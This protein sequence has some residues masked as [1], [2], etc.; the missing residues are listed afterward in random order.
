MCPCPSLNW[1]QL[2]QI[3]ASLK[4]HSNR[5]LKLYSSVIPNPPSIHLIKGIKFHNKQNT[6]HSVLSLSYLFPQWNHQLSTPV[7][8]DL[9]PMRGYWPYSWA[10]SPCSHLSI[11]T[12]D[13]RSSRSLT[14]NRFVTSIPTC[15]LFCCWFWSWL[16][17]CWLIWKRVLPGL[18]LTGYIGWGVL[19]LGF[20]SFSWF[21][22]WF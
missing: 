17:L 10:S 6:P 14:R 11:S 2:Y 21:L 18:M 7:P 8:E 1:Q 20:L 3:E 12:G 19:L 13:P 9:Y 5:K 4:A 22:H 15:C 16:S